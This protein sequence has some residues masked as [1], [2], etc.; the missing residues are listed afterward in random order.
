MDG[1]KEKDEVLEQELP[2]KSQYSNDKKSWWFRRNQ[3]HI[4]PSAQEEIIIEDFD[5]YYLGNTEEKVIYL[6]FDEGYENGYTSQ[7]LDILKEN[8]IQA[9]FFV[10]QP[11]V[12]QQQ[13]LV[14]RMID[15]GHVVGNHSITHPD[16]TTLSDEQVIHEIK[17]MEEYYQEVMGQSMDPFFRPP[18]GNYSERTLK[19]TQEVG[20]KTI[21][22]SMA[23]QDWDI[24]NQPGKET[25]YK[26]VMDNHHSGAIILL[27]AVS[28]SNTEALDQIL[29]DL[30][31]EGYQ[32][33]SL[34]DLP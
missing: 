17:G 16:L 33:K 8:E 7:I 15:E 19:L 30:K 12:K 4:P 26:H 22:W 1:Y 10:T 5:T 18:S 24:N 23:Y 28:Q 3:E 25:A 34:Y 13:D 29:Q 32:F 2:K 27:H 21:F 6:T 11:Y 31:Q 14:Q 20:Y 9:A